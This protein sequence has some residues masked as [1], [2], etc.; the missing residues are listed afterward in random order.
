MRTNPPIRSLNRYILV[1]LVLAAALLTSCDSKPHIDED[2]LTK[3]IVNEAFT[4]IKA[5]EATKTI[6]NSN[7]HYA[8][9]ENVPFSL[10]DTNKEVASGTIIA[11]ADHRNFS[12]DLDI[13]GLDPDYETEYLH[14]GRNIGDIGI[15]MSY[16][17]PFDT[18]WQT[19]IEELLASYKNPDIAGT[20]AEEILSITRIYS[21]PQDVEITANRVHP[22]YNGSKTE[23]YVTLDTVIKSDDQTIRIVSKTEKSESGDVTTTVESLTVNDEAKSVSLLDSTVLNNISKYVMALYRIDI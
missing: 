6:F 14:N 20:S 17:Q 13:E 9:F 16:P 23:D 4:N 19:L 12:F 5:K 15:I 2:V 18:E 1:V 21:I 10:L 11:S 7:N 3:T 22:Y 8:R